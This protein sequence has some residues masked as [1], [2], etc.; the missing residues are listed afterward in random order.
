[1]RAHQNSSPL[2][3]LAGPLGLLAPASPQAGKAAALSATPPREGCG[4]LGQWLASR[5]VRKDSWEGLLG[6]EG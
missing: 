4:H 1:M 6:A 2:L 5:W 3:N